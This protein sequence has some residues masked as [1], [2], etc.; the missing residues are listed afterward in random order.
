MEWCR[1]HQKQYWL[2]EYNYPKD[3]SYNDKASIG[4]EYP[5]DVY[6][7][8]LKADKTMPR[9]EE[10]KLYRLPSDEATTLVYQ[11]GDEI[12]VWFVESAS[13]S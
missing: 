5:K 10:D 6:L 4:L 13:E 2:H 8:V 9:W 12:E 7:V 11:D 1:E 3:F